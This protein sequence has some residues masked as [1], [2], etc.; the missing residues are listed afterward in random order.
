MRQVMDTLM[1]SS[2]LE[3]LLTI[4]KQISG[5]KVGDDFMNE[6]Q[7]IATKVPYM[8]A[9]GNHEKAYNFSHY[10]NRF[11][12]PGGQA[13]Y[14]YS[15]DVG[16]AH[17]ILFSTEVYFYFNYGPELVRYQ[18]EWLEKD[19]KEVNSRKDRPWII[20]GAHR[21]MYCST[22]D[23]DDCNHREGT[24]RTGHPFFHE[25]GLEKLFY[26][27]GVDIELWA[28]EH[29]YQRM[30]PVYNR[31]VYNGSDS[32]PYVDPKAPVHVITGSAGYREG[33]TLFREPM[34]WDA[35]RYYDYGYSYL[36]VINSTHVK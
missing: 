7:D 4:L 5:G 22:V 2:T 24:V 36:T 30:W 21:P 8:T 26:D 12:M 32:E 17:F 28:H 16:N 25:Y 27:Y 35:V 23:V 6:I 20:T 3:I 14:Y 19:L 29:E 33:R 9:P 34:P 15:W 11:A 13:N 10:I 18:Y 31:T 1:P